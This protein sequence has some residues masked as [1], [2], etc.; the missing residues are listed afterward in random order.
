MPHSWGISRAKPGQGP[1]SATRTVFGMNARPHPINAFYLPHS[2]ILGRLSWAIVY[3]DVS[4]T[5]S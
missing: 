3:R 1:L 2:K 4:L 5:A